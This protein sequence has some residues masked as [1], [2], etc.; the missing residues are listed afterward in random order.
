MIEKFSKTFCSVVIELIVV[1][2]VVIIVTA[3][4]LP[5]FVVDGW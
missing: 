1:V 2:V 5:A 4:K 3:A